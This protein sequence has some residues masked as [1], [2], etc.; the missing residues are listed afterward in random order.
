MGTSGKSDLLAFRSRMNRSPR[1]E[2]I[3]KVHT[4]IYK[5]LKHTIV[6]PIFLAPS[7]E[8]HGIWKTHIP[9]YLR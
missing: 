4:T 6:G 2:K 5:P 7:P 9:A 1:P 3:L 8:P